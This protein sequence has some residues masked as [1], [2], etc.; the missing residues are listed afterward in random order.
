MTDETHTETHHD[1][2]EDRTDDRTDDHDDRIEDRTDDRIEDHDDDRA[3][4]RPGSDRFGRLSASDVRG[5]LDRVAL[6]ALVLLALIAGWNVYG[7]VGTAIRTWLDPAYQ[8]V[9]LAA[10]N[11]AVLMV[12]LAGV[13]HQLRRLRTDEES[14]IGTTD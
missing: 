4:D 6:A 9:A 5:V 1:R 2:I 13:I 7:H 14:G 8:S 3:T 11:L 10:F 12:A